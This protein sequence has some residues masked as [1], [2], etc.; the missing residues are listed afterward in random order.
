MCLQVC[1]CRFVLAVVGVDLWVSLR[2]R[3]KA[4]GW[5]N[6]GALALS[7]IT[8]RYVRRVEYRA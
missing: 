2:V 7:H 3:R 5:S 4:S 6:R 8:Q 1:R